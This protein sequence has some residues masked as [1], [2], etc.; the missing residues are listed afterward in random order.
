MAISTKQKSKII[1]EKKLKEK[2]ALLQSNDLKAQLTR[3][4]DFKYKI[5][6]IEG[7]RRISGFTN[8]LDICEFVIYRGASSTIPFPVNVSLMLDC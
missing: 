4:E 1:R 5:S 7:D 6:V 8:D 2:I 3:L